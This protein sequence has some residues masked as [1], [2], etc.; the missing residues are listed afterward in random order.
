MKFD[1]KSQCSKERFTHMWICIISHL[2]QIVQNLL[3]KQI[4]FKFN[5]ILFLLKRSQDGP[6]ILDKS[7][8]LTKIIII[9][10][11]EVE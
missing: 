9:L 10:K 11:Q 1:I 8:E 4:I 7:R 5:H 6:N 3:L 2:S